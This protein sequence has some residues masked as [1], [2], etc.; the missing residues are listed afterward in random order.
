MTVNEVIEWLSTKNPTSHV[1]I[2]SQCGAWKVSGS[3]VVA[4]E[5]IDLSKFKEVQLNDQS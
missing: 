3:L 1:K 5:K 4:N 2:E